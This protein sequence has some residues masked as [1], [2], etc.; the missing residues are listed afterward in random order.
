[1]KVSAPV[2]D[3]L[4]PK[5]PLKLAATVADVVALSPRIELA[6]KLAYVNTLPRS[7]AVNSPVPPTL[8]PKVAPLATVIRPAVVW[9][10]SDSTLV[11]CSVPSLTLVEPV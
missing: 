4:R 3:L 2:P 6:A 11:T 10:G 5:A 8:R 9:P 7:V 1:M